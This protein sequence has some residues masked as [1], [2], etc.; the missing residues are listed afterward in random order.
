VL[1][2]AVRTSLLAQVKDLKRGVVL[3]GAPSLDVAGQA[4]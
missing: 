3:G 4:R 1:P 2:E